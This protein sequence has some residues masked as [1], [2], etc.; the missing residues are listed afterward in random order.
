[1]LPLPFSG[2]ITKVIEAY[3]LV[4]FLLPG[5]SSC[6]L[7]G[8]KLPFG[9]SIPFKREGKTCEGGL[10]CPWPRLSVAKMEGGQ[11]II[12]TL[13]RY[14]SERWNASQGPNFSRRK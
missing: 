14:Y 8:A 12:T 4:R 5:D 6:G 3:W 13:I 10:G 11:P 7:Q 2:M 1:M 9:G